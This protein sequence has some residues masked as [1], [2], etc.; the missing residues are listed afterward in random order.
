MVPMFASL[1]DITINFVYY[2]V[3]I[4]NY[5]QILIDLF[6]GS[7]TMLNVLLVVCSSLIYV[8]VVIYL[9]IKKYKVE[10]ILF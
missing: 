7:A 9:V 2:L 1:L 4:F 10:E 5:V 8:L 3:P 6:S